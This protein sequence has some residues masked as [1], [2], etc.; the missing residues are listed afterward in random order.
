MRIGILVS[1]LMGGKL[2]WIFARGTRSRLRTT[3]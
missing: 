3:G 1:G 2:G